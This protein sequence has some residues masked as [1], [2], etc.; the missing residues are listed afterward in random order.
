VLLSASSGAT[1][2]P[3]L[4]NASTITTYKPIEGNPPTRGLRSGEPV[5]TAAV[6]QS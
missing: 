1:E 3:R 6:G 5:M 2:R 4:W